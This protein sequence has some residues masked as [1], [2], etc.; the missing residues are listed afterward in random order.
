MFN[1]GDKA[2]CINDEG[3]EFIKNGHVYIVLKTGN[4][5]YDSFGNTKE[6]SITVSTEDGDIMYLAARFLNVA[7]ITKLE[8]A[9][10]GVENEV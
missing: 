4:D 1:V 2:F 10:Y 3:K 8:L 6:P 5:A 9:L 7:R